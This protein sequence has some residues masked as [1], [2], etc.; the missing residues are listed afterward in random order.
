MKDTVKIQVDIPENISSVRPLY[1]PDTFGLPVV[2]KVGSNV[3]RVVWE[4]ADYDTAG[5]NV[6]YE[7]V[8]RLRVADV[9]FTK[10]AFNVTQ[11]CRD[12]TGDTVVAW[13][14]PDDTAGSEAPT[15][16]VGSRTGSQPASLLTRLIAPPA[17]PRPK[18]MPFGPFS[19]SMRSML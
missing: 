8:L 15:L 11:T 1:G 14:D 4:K 7:F 6:Y 17:A 3:T 18:I 13:D 10:V 19:T 2:T 5:D 12:A 16:T 9:P